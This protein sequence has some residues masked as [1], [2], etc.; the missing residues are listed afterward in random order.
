MK[1]LLQPWATFSCLSLNWY[2]A[3]FFRQTSINHLP[4]GVYV[5]FAFH[6]LRFHIAPFS[7]ADFPFNCLPKKN[8]YA[9]QCSLSFVSSHSC[10]SYHV[11]SLAAWFLA[12]QTGLVSLSFI[13]LIGACS[14]RTSRN[15]I[16]YT[17][18]WSPMIKISRPLKR[19]SIKTRVRL[20]R[21]FTRVLG[22][23]KTVFSRNDLQDPVCI[24]SHNCWKPLLATQERLS[25]CT[26]FK[27]SL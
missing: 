12:W 4:Y 7:Q 25:T 26:T 18:T 5:T 20:S 11:F 2:A 3:R 15:R 6:N 22:G 10:T 19:E 1:Y 9:F 16:L 17:S 13:L 14:L 27:V 8:L 24:L 21:K 23:R